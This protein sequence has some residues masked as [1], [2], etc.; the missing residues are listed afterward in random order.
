MMMM[1]MTM[2]T[3]PNHDPSDR[4]SHCHCPVMKIMI[5]IMIR[6]HHHHH[7]DDDEWDDDDDDA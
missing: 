3:V 4:P 6:H 1:G 2:H 7:H 5:G